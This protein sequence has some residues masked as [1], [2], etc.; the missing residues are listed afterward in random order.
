MLLK[1]YSKG[2]SLVVQWLKTC[3]TVRGMWV[4]SLVGELRS[5]MSLERLVQCRAATESARHSQ[6]QK[7]LRDAV[8]T[9]QSQI[10]R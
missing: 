2:M 3:L 10:N 1:M 5:H 9:P 6:A 4:P 8:K 7:I